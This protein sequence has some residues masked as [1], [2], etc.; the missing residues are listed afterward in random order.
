MNQ[1]P[2]PAFA[3]TGR[4]YSVIELLIVMTILA[5][6][7]TLAQTAWAKH[8]INARRTEATTSLLSAAAAQESFFSAT[9]HYAAELW[10]PFPQGLGLAE[11]ENDWY[12]LSVE[13]VGGNSFVMAARPL[14]GSAQGRDKDC[15]VFTID[16]AGRR[17]SAPA[18]PG[19]CWR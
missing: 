1:R 16:Q 2:V 12:G 10:L 11:T 9:R 17:G 14:P 13:S 15:L 18:Q 3:K 6:L 19:I 8:M 7:A 4:G 5:I